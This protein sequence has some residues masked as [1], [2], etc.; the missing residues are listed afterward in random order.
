LSNVSLIV[1]FIESIPNNM[2]IVQL[3]LVTVFALLA[4]AQCRRHCELDRGNLCSGTYKTFKYLSGAGKNPFHGL[5]IPATRS[6]STYVKERAKVSFFDV[7]N[8]GLI[9]IVFGRPGDGTLG[10]WKNTGTKSNPAF[11]LKDTPSTNPFYY[12]EG[13]KGSGQNNYFPI[14]DF[15]DLYGKGMPDVVMAD[16]TDYFTFYSNVGTIGNPEY[17]M[18]TGPRN[19]IHGNDPFR[20]EHDTRLNFGFVASPTFVDLDNDDDID[21]VVGHFDGTLSYW[22]NVGNRTWPVFKQQP[23]SLNPFNYIAV[24]TYVETAMVDFDKDGDYDLVCG[25]SNWKLRYFENTG[26]EKSPSFTS[27]TLDENPF[28]GIAA[29]TATGQMFLLTPYFAD[30]YG[31]GNLDL[32]VTNENRVT[33]TTASEQGLLF[34][35]NMIDRAKPRYVPQLGSVE[36]NP[37][38][39]TNSKYIAPAFAD[40]DSDGDLD[41]FYG[42]RSGNI[43][44]CMNR[45]NAT[46][47]VFGE[48]VFLKDNSGNVIVISS[49][50][51]DLSS[52]IARVTVALA[53]VNNDGKMDMLL[54]E[55]R[56]NI[57]FYENTGT[58]TSYEFTAKTGGANPFNGITDCR[59]KCAVALA[60]L[61]NDGKYDLILGHQ[62][63]GLVYYENTG[64]A[65]TPAYTQ[66]TGT[67]TNPNPFDGIVTDSKNSPTFADADKDGDLDMVIGQH[68]SIYKDGMLKYYE[69][70]GSSTAPTFVARAGNKNPFETIEFGR[71]L[72]AVFA[73]I[74]SD[75]ELELIVGETFGELNYLRPNKCNQLTQCSGFSK[76]PLTTSQTPT[77]PCAGTTRGGAQCQSCPPGW[78]ENP[79]TE[80]SVTL[81]LSVA[82]CVACPKGRWNSQMS[83]PPDRAG[84]INACT[85][86]APGKF[87]TTI[88]AT[89]EA[90]GCEEC[91]VGR[92]ANAYAVPEFS[93]CTLCKAGQSTNEITGRTECTNCS[94]GKYTDTEGM[95]SCV[96]C[97]ASTFSSQPGKMRCSECLAGFFTST[98]GA[99]HCLQCPSGQT[100]D[101]KSTFCYECKAGEYLITPATAAPTCKLCDSGKYSEAGA[102]TCSWCPPGRWTKQDR[103]NGT[104]S[105]CHSCPAG[106]YGVKSGATSFSEQ[107]RYCPKGTFSAAV[108]AGDP[109]ACNTCAPGKYS[110]GVGAN[111]SQSC[112]TCPLGKVA[113]TFG[114]ETCEVCSSRRYP[115]SARSDCLLC[116]LGEYLVGLACVPC[117]PG[118]YED[119]KGSVQCKACPVNTFS[120]EVGNVAPEKCTPCIDVF[121]NTATGG[122]LGATMSSACQCKIGTYSNPDKS[123]APDKRCQPCLVGSRCNTFN[124]SV[125]MLESEQNYWRSSLTSTIF[126][127]CDTIDENEYCT[128]GSLLNE[129]QCHEGHTGPLCMVCKEGYVQQGNGICERCKN[130]T[131]KKGAGAPLAFALALI[132]FF[133]TMTMV[134]ARVAKDVIEQDDDDDDEEDTSSDDSE[135]AEGDLS[136]DDGETKASLARMRSRRGSTTT[137]EGWKALH[138]LE[139]QAEESIMDNIMGEV[140]GAVMGAVEGPVKISDDTDARVA[141]EMA[142]HTRNSVSMVMSDSLKADLSTAADTVKDIQTKIAG[143]SR[144]FVSFIQV[145][146]N[147]ATTFTIPWPQEFLNFVNL[148]FF[149]ALSVDFA[150]FIG[151]FNPC[152][153]HTSYLSRF[154][155]HIT[156]MPILLIIVLIACGVVGLI[157][158]LHM[159]KKIKLCGP[160][161]CA[162]ER[163]TDIPQFQE[164]K[165]A[166]IE[167]FGR[168]VNMIIFL[169]YPG[170]SVKIFTIFR[171]VELDPG[172]YFLVADLSVKCFSG[173]WNSTAAVAGLC[174]VV[175]VIG[176]PLG[177]F[178]ILYKKKDI[179]RHGKP[180]EKDRLENVYG[181]LYVQ[182][183]PKYYWWEVFEM[184]KKM[185]LTGGLVMLAPGSS[186]QILV[187]VIITLIYYSLVLKLEP[188]E[189]DKDDFLQFIASTQIL[190]TLIMGFALRSDDKGSY[191]KTV[192]SVL[193]VF[194]NSLMFVLTAYVI[195]ITTKPL[196]GLL[197]KTFCC[198]LHTV[199]KKSRRIGTKLSAIVPVS[200]FKL[201]T[202]TS[203]SNNDTSEHSKVLPPRSK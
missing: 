91:P 58:S 112:L 196:R 33:G 140:E 106:M 197:C 189:D 92:Y 25:D 20:D 53:D 69:N 132:L 89:S 156:L 86:C 159:K 149:K 105:G 109:N 178:F 22:E 75:G 171:C 47:P 14:I 42:Q 164:I 40:I 183:E 118:T 126:H 111:E 191:D 103:T 31:T 167:R 179:I 78:Y 184:I 97:R 151:F 95:S 154:T 114:A 133:I 2:K 99:T 52:G 161:A 71:E 166:M 198:C 46:H 27:R 190:L 30:I 70:T 131:H 36:M 85:P 3:Q 148:P 157:V 135:V 10:Y 124:L 145:F 116:S 162:R 9:D 120:G 115:N 98:P 172:E 110:P 1:C 108:A 119:S 11:T 195:Y 13:F 194:T 79:I 160:C 76:C 188:Y 87:G 199:V 147:F 203:A 39:T 74:N 202:G 5:V 136:P 65:N 176:I 192:I 88:G 12:V 63:S 57:Y 90:I 19:G 7:N 187:A 129:S 66:R 173:A 77:C 138:E 201:P 62:Y 51:T 181:S 94:A 193:L 21:I 43:M 122:V 68:S 24:G 60:D 38:P 73:D 152:S 144:I 141:E 80:Y 121:P 56:G 123:A 18:K 169:M 155:Y 84:P 50:S 185:L 174:I 16:T 55:N 142:E 168:F 83:K 17:E 146:S 72:K 8:D 96:D 134:F 15:V 82:E 186:A 26:N 125:A 180:E 23:G 104:S 54:G 163:N 37:L 6:A 153:L 32:I 158:H 49:R 67:G 45:G 107:C 44:L 200:S 28:D 150:A 113:T 34:F 130:L 4:T 61:N 81:E 100:S 48:K 175:Y 35:K 143:F 177:T 170:L 137:K 64:G 127:P 41:L 29:D 59:D 117:Q 93:G 101:R 102:I 128:G 182:Y 139:S 165:R